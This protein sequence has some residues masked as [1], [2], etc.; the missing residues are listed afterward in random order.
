[1][2][3]RYGLTDQEWE[4]TAPL[5]PSEKTGKPGTAFPSKRGAFANGNTY[6]PCSTSTLEKRH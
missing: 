5:L 3:K 6:C 4:Q 2:L 1:M